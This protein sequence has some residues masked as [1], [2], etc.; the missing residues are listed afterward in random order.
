MDYEDY[1]LAPRIVKQTLIKRSMLHPRLIK[2]ARGG[3]KKAITNKAM[4]LPEYA[5]VKF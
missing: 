4:S 2:T 5:M 1:L 3:K